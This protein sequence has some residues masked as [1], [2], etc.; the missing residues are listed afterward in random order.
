MTLNLSQ[1]MKNINSFMQWK[2][3]TV[4]VTIIHQKQLAQS[5]RNMQSAVDIFNA[6]CVFTQ[7]PMRE[8]EIKF[9]WMNT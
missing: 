6:L 9:E 3:G 5:G 4:E 7:E 8:Q 1:N 2:N